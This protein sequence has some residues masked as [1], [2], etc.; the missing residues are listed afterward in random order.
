MH[1]PALA[2][3]ILRRG[4]SYFVDSYPSLNMT[5]DNT[6][7]SITIPT[8]L[9]SYT[10]SKSQVYAQGK[11]ILDLIDD[12]ERQYRG[13]RF[14]MVD[15]QG[16]LRPHLKVFVNRQQQQSL[17]TPVVSRDEIIFVQAFSGG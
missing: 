16:R 6:E 2:A 10:N 12:L 17:A 5:Y 15:E 4:E 8:A 7:L 14:R 3:H 1:S 11:T 13:I 9:H